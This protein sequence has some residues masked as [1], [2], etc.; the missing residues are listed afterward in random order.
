[1]IYSLCCPPR[2]HA[3]QGNS[4]GFFFSNNAVIATHHLRQKNA[5]VAIINIDPHAGQGTQDIFYDRG[6]VLFASIDV[7]PSDYP[8]SLPAT[9]MNGVLVT[10]LGAS[11]N[12]TSNKSS[13]ESII[14][15]GIEHMTARAKAPLALKS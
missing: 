9:L 13:N 4:N 15:D 10:I 2:H 8:H 5:R 11:I 3:S 12:I 7:D 14:L 6:D 1:L